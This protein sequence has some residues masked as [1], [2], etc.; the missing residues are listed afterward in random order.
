MKNEILYIGS[1]ELPDMNAA[2]HRVMNN[3]KIFRELGYKVV[4]YGATRN[5]KC[6]SSNFQDFKFLYYDYPNTIRSWMKF[7][8]TSKHVINVA[9]NLENLKIIV[10]Y[11]YPAIALHKI[12]KY[13][14]KKGIVVIS[15]TTEWYTDNRILKNIDTLLRMKYVNY[16]VNG[17]ICI[18]EYLAN[19]YSEIDTVLLPP[20]VDIKDEKWKSKIITHYNEKLSLIFTGTIGKNKERLDFIIDEFLSSGLA[21]ICSLSIYGTNLINLK[22][23]YKKYNSIDKIDGISFYDK[24]SHSESINKLNEADYLVFFRDNNRSNNAGFPTKF[25]ESVTLNIPVITNNTSDLEKY[26]HNNELGEII[27]MKSG[28]LY[29]LVQKKFWE[30][31]VIKS[32]DEFNKLFHYENYLVLMEDFLDRIKLTHD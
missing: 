9:C 2:A 14:K 13:A 15:D 23:I 17:I 3:G 24:I 32:K 1:F 8:F 10:A 28:E 16:E 20:L 27:E 26:L 7:L 6:S 31:K 30:K 25:V 4:F 12:I 22:R 29:K 18:S 11:N 21:N 5:K 19:Y